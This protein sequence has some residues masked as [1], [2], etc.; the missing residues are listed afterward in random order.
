MKRLILFLAFVVISCGALF[1]THVYSYSDGITEDFRIR[2]SA[3]PGGTIDPTGNVMVP[4]GGNQKFDFTPNAG[5][6]ILEVLVDDVNNPGA[7]INGFYIFTNVVE[8]HT[9]RVNFEPIA[10]DWTINA[11]VTPATGGSINPSGNISVSNGGSQTFTFSANPGYHISAVVVDGHNEPLTSPYTFT[12]V[13][14]NHTIKIFF[15]LDGGGGGDT[16]YVVLFPNPP[17][18]GTCTGGGPYEPDATANIEAFPNTGLGYIFDRWTDYYTGATI[19]DANPYSFPVTENCVYEA[20]FIM[21]TYHIVVLASPGNGGTVT[22]G[23]SYFYNATATATATVANDCWEFDSWTKM[24]GTPITTVNPYSFPVTEDDTLVANF[25]PKTYDIVLEPDPSGGGFPTVSGAPTLGGSYPCGANLEIGALVANGYQFVKWTK[26]NGQTVSNTID[27]IHSVSGPDT[28]VVHFTEKTYNVILSPEPGG[29][30]YTMADGVASSG[31]NYP[32]GYPLQINAEAYTGWEFEKWEEDGSDFALTPV[33]SF[34]VTETHILKALFKKKEYEIYVEASPLSGGTVTISGTGPYPHGELITITADT[35]ACYKFINWTKDG[36]HVSYNA[37]H[38][39]AAS[40]SGTYVAHFEPKTYNI[41]VEADPGSG[42]TVGTSGVY[43]CNQEI[44]IWTM[45]NDGYDFINWTDEGGTVYTPLSFQFIVTGS[46]KFTA[47]YEIR[48]I[49]IEVF[50][51]PAPPNPGG[52]AI[53]VTDPPFYYGDWVEVNAIPDPGYAFINWTENNVQVSPNPLYSFVAHQDR[54][55]IANFT[56]KMYNIILSVYPDGAGTVNGAG[57]YPYNYDLSVLATANEGWE[58]VEWTEYGIGHVSYDNP[59]SFT[60][61]GTRILTANFQRKEFTITVLANTSAGGS[62]N[63]GG[64]Y[65]FEQTA[66]V[67]AEHNPGWAFIEWTES[68]G[69]TQASPLAEYSFTVTG[70]RTLIAHF[71]QEDYEITVSAQPLTYGNA[72]VIEPLPPFHYGDSCSVWAYP[73]SNYHFV[74]W[75]ENDEWV[76][77]DQ[78]WKFKVTR[79]R[80]LVAYF[81]DNTYTVTLEAD[82]PTGG[83]LE[84]ADDY[85]YDT[86]VTILAKPNTGFNFQKWTDETGTVSNTVDYTFHVKNSCTFTAHFTRLN[87]DIVLFPNPDPEGGTVEGA[88]NYLYEDIITVKAY[89][90]QTYEF[91]NW[92]NEDGSWASDD[93]FYEFIVTESRT[94]T[95]N[96]GPRTFYITLLVSPDGSGTVNGEGS[97][98]YKDEATIEAIPNDCYRF[99][100][101]TDE[102]G[103]EVSDQLLFSFEVI[104]NRTFTANFLGNDTEIAL[105]VNP[106]GSGTVTG[107]GVYPCGDLITVNATANQHYEFVNWTNEDGSWASDDPS[108]TLKLTG[109]TTLTA[110]FEFEKH[111]II[112][113]ASPEDYGSV[114]G[115]GK[116]SYGQNITVSAVAD[117]LY[118]FVNWTEGDSIVSLDADYSFKVIGSRTLVAHFKKLQYEVIANPDNEEYGSTTGS[119]MYEVNTLAVVEAFTKDCYL[120]KNWM[121]GDSIV[122]TANPYEFIVKG[123]TTIV[124]HFYTLDFDT[125][126]LTMWNNT[127]MLNLKKLREDGFDVIN[128]KWFKNGIELKT[129]NTINEFSY[130]A[131]PRSTDLLEPSPTY[132]SFRL[133]TRNHGELCST[134]KKINPSANTPAPENKMW[135]YP[136]PVMAGMPFTVEGVA[137]NDEVRVYNQYGSCVHS[138]IAGGE[139]I[140]LTLNVEAGVYVVKANGKQVKVVIVR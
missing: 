74:E 121:I 88:G 125:Y 78:F 58:F 138:A 99:I 86:E 109:A 72:I 11:S 51:N 28:L 45:P 46:K 123:N 57:V 95:A 44:E 60:V 75:R 23:G 41:I 71:V 54:T 136:N 4:S 29:A 14:A 91:I 34:L 42:G 108:Y 8:E 62:V 140:I 81:T 92:T 129:T 130:S 30:G 89:P 111:D 33:H 96:F 39:F 49:L 131:G 110:N 52:T 55:L 102:N 77:G 26:K 56:P 134:V 103:D 10:G 122:S 135:A 3:G 24:D 7:V 38:T 37:I 27:F 47:H 84:G 112:L 115:A 133:F 6:Q 32:Y 98:L 12:N 87:Y 116:Y 20:Q 50:S 82:P 117:T 43:P 66:T 67:T 80:D 79:S 65:L 64:S 127:F 104:E 25:I 36:G 35:A 114:F 18:G 53:I 21:E 139:T 124:A 16:F 40:G 17:G 119:G 100:N 19:T 9:I 113:L 15:T 132:Y 93:A 13:T 68:D 120:F 63:G 70:N 118:S 97:Y 76:S 2:A 61:T 83:E 128:C 31:G 1:A 105:Q 5:F 85:L 48:E 69:V 107:D 126:C 106:P 137:Q 59:Y 101:W 73:N 90:N 94:L 22:G